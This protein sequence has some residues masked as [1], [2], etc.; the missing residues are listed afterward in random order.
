[1]TL[2]KEETYLTFL[3]LQ[4]LVKEKP[5][6]S[7]RLWGKI[8]GLHK[9]Y[10]IT[11]GELKD[12]VEDDEPAAGEG[13]VHAADMDGA[14]AAAA[15]PVTGAD[16]GVVSE[17]D[18][19]LPKPKVKAVKPL[20]KEVRSGVNKYVYYV[21]TQRKFCVFVLFCFFS[22]SRFLLL[23]HPSYILS[24]V[25]MIIFLKQKKQQ[26]QQQQKSAGSKWFRLPDVIP[27]KLQISRKIRKYFTG[28][29]FRPVSFLLLVI[30]VYLTQK[31]YIL[32]NRLSAT[33]PLMVQRRSTFD[34]RLLASPPPQLQVLLV[35][36]PLTHQRKTEKKKIVSCL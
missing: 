34:A 20:S 32:F 1:V 25:S 3:S 14:A 30:E 9:S 10:I 16:G 22:G 29:L 17:E 5:L 36:T 2:G 15:E 13:A 33:L 12:G 18:P 24:I 27:E 4:Q 7:V 31:K 23:T 11:E 21:T 6:K 28:D 19:T 8:H 26:L 35:T